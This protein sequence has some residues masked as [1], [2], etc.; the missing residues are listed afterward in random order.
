MNATEISES[1]RPRYVAV[2]AQVSTS[3]KRLWPKKWQRRGMKMSA[4][5]TREEIVMSLAC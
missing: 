1:P 4:E 5:R 2:Y 3:A